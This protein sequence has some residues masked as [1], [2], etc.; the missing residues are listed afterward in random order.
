M[1]ISIP[2]V[3]TK[4]LRMLQISFLSGADILGFSCVFLLLTAP[5]SMGIDTLWVNYQQMNSV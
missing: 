5:M 2:G 3:I 4:V 1:W